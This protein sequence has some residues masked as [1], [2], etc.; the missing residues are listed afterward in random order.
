MVCREIDIPP[1]ITWN[2][3]VVLAIACTRYR[4]LLKR[5][6]AL[7]FRAF[8]RE[9]PHPQLKIVYLSIISLIIVRCV[10]TRL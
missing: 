9:L 10:S 1:V 3:T 6:R 7:S 4:P 5:G 2:A 8:P